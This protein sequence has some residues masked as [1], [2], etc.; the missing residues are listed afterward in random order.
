MCKWTKFI[1]IFDT[2]KI[3]TSQIADTQ[4][5]TETLL[6]NNNLKIT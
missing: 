1:S 5:E 6:S 4:V 3:S 2:G